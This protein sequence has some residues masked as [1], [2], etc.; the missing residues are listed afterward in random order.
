[1]SD[2]QSLQVIHLAAYGAVL[3]D[4]E[5]K[6][7]G[8]AIYGDSGEHG[9]GVGGP[10]HVPHLAAEVIHDQGARVILDDGVSDAQ[11]D[12]SSIPPTLCH[13]LTVYSAAQE[14]NTEG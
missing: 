11:G 12:S 9:A 1:M 6:H 7:H 2:L 8:P 13:T 10:G 3:V 4:R 14:R 5:V